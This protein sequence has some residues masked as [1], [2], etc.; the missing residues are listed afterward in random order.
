MMVLS[1]TAMAPL[2]VTAAL[3]RNRKTL[4]RRVAA[5]RTADDADFVHGF[6][7]MVAAVEAGFRREEVLLEALTGACPAPRL[8]DHAMLLCALHRT[9]PRV[10]GKDVRLGR[11]IVDA[12]DA[13]LLLPWQFAACPPSYAHCGAVGLRQGVK[14][15]VGAF[16]VHHARSW[17][18]RSTGLE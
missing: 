17:R 11:E 13:V 1:H 12:L 9:M 16:D 10:E 14:Q 18:R 6:T 4:R 2:V 5:L 15:S 3:N 8:A 7:Q